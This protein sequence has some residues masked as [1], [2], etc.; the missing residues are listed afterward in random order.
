MSR[1]LATYK[2]V[3]D[4]MSDISE[5]ALRL[6]A[7]SNGIGTVPLSSIPDSN[8]AY[9]SEIVD[10]TTLSDREIL[11][12]IGID[13]RNVVP[14]KGG[15]PLILCFLFG[16]S[17]RGKQL[18]KIKLIDVEFPSS[19]LACFEGPKFGLP[20]LEQLLGV[21][22]PFL[23]VV[24]IPSIGSSAGSFAELAFKIS[25][26]GADIVVDD[27]IF[28]ETEYL[29]VVDRAKAV[30]ARLDNLRKATMYAVNITADA[31]FMMKVADELKA[32][33]TAKFKIALR[34]CPIATGFAMLCSLRSVPL[35]KYAYST[36]Q[37]LLTEDIQHGIDARL[38]AGIMRVLGADFVYC[39]AIPG[40][41]AATQG[42]AISIAK[43]LTVPW[44]YE[45]EGQRKEIRSSI[46][47][48]T[49]G[50][51]PGNVWCNLNELGCGVTLHTG[52][53]AFTHPGGVTDGVRAFK[54][55]VEAYKAGEVLDD[56]IEADS[57]Y[58]QLRE[59]CLHPGHKFMSQRNI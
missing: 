33:E 56:L 5:I 22:P 35:P 13:A 4:N 30:R 7:E 34:F 32:L 25:E 19:Y 18:K 9:F 41:Y 37:R 20:G 58:K 49:G 38:L 57:K 48:I 1:I 15:I 28:G 17:F 42:E 16:D 27:D 47:I 26:A 46:P 21:E 40:S 52:S 53:A 59:S 50:L 11:L 55:A 45:H 2:C 24:V 23:S 43:K 6:C 14:D 36:L 44:D 54:Q 51:T 31:P 10:I 39:G 29:A 12:K 8:K 3:V